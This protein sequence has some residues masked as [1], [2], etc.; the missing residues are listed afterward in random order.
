[1]AD[2]ALLFWRQYLRRPLGIGAV[3]PSGPALA[4]RMVM[5]LGASPG[6]KVVEI[7]PGTGPFT[8]ALLASGINPQRLLLVEFDPGFVGHLRRTFP[9]VTVVEGDAGNLP[10]ILKDHGEEDVPRILSGLPLRSMPP[11]IRRRISAAMAQALRKGGSLVQF[12][13]F[14]SAPLDEAAVKA[15]GLACR[16]AALVAA[17]IPPAFVWHYRKPAAA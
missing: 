1:M 12:T 4:K 3:A 13:Y 8:R 2:G 5:T 16:R 7:G 14:L 6:D 17:N 10:D 9:G 15:H 11:E